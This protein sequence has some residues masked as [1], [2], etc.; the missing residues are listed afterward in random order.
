ME[1][2][3]IHWLK[4]VV[5]AVVDLAKTFVGFITSEK[6]PFFKSEGLRRQ[7][8]SSSRGVQNADHTQ[9]NSRFQGSEAVKAPAEMAEQREES[10]DVDSRFR[11][12]D[13]RGETPMKPAEQESGT[14]MAELAGDTP[15]QECESRNDIR[16]EIPLKPAEQESENEEVDSLFQGSEAAAPPAEIAEQEEESETPLKPAEQESENEDAASRFQGSE[17]MKLPSGIAEQKEE[18]ETAA[19]ESETAEQE[20]ETKMA[21]LAGDTPEQGHERGNDV[22]GETPP[23]PAEQES[24]N[25]DAA[26]RF[27]GSEA[28]APPAEMAE[29]RSETNKSRSFLMLDQKKSSALDQLSPLRQTLE[30]TKHYVNSYILFVFKT[31]SFI[32][33]KWSPHLKAQKKAPGSIQKPSIFRIVSTK[34]TALFWTSCTGI[35]QQLFFQPM[36]F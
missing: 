27:Q 32:P 16:G 23:K 30:K 36:G 33:C 17:A 22:R 24:Q 18:G 34:Q 13:V 28:A 6:N 5:F 4:S 7:P 26:S 21:E 9:M 1:F 2:E 12:N 15:E 10:E 8:K 11:G 3:Y 25:E 20:S 29:Q 14:K 31:D 35:G 19:P